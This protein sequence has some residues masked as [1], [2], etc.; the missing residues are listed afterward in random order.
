M[1]R[2]LIVRLVDIT[3]LLLLSLMAIASINPYS[4]VLPSSTALEDRGVLLRPL[5]V[6]V[7]AEGVLLTVGDNGALTER[8]PRGIAE[9]AQANTQGVEVVV[10][11]AATAST[12][13]ALHQVLQDHGVAVTFL[14]ERTQGNRRSP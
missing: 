3:L 4:V 12:L 8:T 2:T 14:V 10:D 11:R 7:T 9:E 13:L 5:Q 6:A 1:K